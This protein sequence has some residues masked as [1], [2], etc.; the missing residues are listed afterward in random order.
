M[1]TSD[2]TEALFESGLSFRNLSK[3][4]KK[5]GKLAAFLSKVR[6]LEAQ[7]KRGSPFQLTMEDDLHLRGPSF[8][9]MLTAACRLYNADPTLDIM[10]LSPFTELMLTSLE[11]ATKMLRLLRLRGIMRSTD[12][13]LLDPRTM[14]NNHRVLKFFGHFHWRKRP[15]VLARAPNS[16]AGLIWRSR[17]MTWAEMALLRL[18]TL[19]GS[20]ALPLHG[21]PP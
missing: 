18:L 16:A 9:R 6:A 21:N 20:R 8:A 3:G 13:Q 12:Q 5:W 2:T 4:A 10:Q 7:V 15:W 17:R 1:N 11:G 19:P 14:G